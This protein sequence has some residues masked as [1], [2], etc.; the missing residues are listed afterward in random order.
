RHA[1]RLGHPAPPPH[2]PRR[3]R[4]RRRRPP[5]TLE[6]V[7]PRLG[8]TTPPRRPFRDH[9]RATGRARNTAELA[10]PTVLGRGS[11]PPALSTSSRTGRA[12]K[13]GA[14]ATDRPINL[15]PDTVAI[16]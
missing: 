10:R 2:H 9:A 12:P 6:L 8:R 11:P 16:R 13:L 3:P 4:T 15:F 7:A 1:A 5:R 14:S